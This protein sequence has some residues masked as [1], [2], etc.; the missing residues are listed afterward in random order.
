M[1]LVNDLSSKRQQRMYIEQLSVQAHSF[2]AEELDGAE[3]RATQRMHSWQQ[4]QLLVR[5]GRMQDPE[6][7]A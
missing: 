5:L 3:Q 7:A 2:T 4:A 1:L 6:A